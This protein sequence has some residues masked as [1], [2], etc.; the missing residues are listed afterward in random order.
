MKSRISMLSIIVGTLLLLS[1]CGLL[2]KEDEPL[3]PPLVEP[4]ATQYETEEVESEELVDSFKAKGSFE[5]DDEKD[6]TSP[7][8]GQEVEEIHV[9]S[10]D[11]VEKGDTLVE[12]ETEDLPLDIKQQKLSVEEAELNL[13]KAKKNADE[14]DNQNDEDESDEKQEEIAEEEGDGE[15]DE[16]SIDNGEEQAESDAERQHQIDSSELDL[17]KEQNELEDL[18]DKLDAATV[19]APISGV[20]T[21]FEDIKEGEE[22]EPD[23]KIA[24][25]SDP[26]SLRLE[27]DDDQNEWDDISNGMDVDVTIGDEDLEAE[28]ADVPDSDSDDN[29]TVDVKDIPDSVDLGES[30]DMEIIFEKRDDVLTVPEDAIRNYDEQAVVRVLDGDDLSEVS[31]ETGL[32]VDDKVEIE[33]GLDEGD[34]V[35]LR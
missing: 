34:E 21:S 16:G 14:N 27:T 10:N 15:E 35:I 5:S 18:R 6:I 24:T 9:E 1:G 13:E 22:L 17:E 28:V 30:A 20:V 33:S 2:P 11:D 3:E 32:E 25:I 19:S 12:M 4:S 26:D 31:V 23:T 7:D 29:L 8:E